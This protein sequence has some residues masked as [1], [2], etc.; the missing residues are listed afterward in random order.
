M[1]YTTVIEMEDRLEEIKKRLDEI[2]EEM[3]AL[4]GEE[5]DLNLEWTEIEDYLIGGSSAEVDN[6]DSSSDSDDA[7]LEE[8]S[9]LDDEEWLDETWTPE[10]E[11]TRDTDDDI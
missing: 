5:S 2:D 1:H 4:I 11:D 9:Y 6:G 10:D 3:D 8:F 7:G